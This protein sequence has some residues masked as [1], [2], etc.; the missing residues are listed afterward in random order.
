MQLVPRLFCGVHHISISLVFSIC[1]IC[2]HAMK[3]VKSIILKHIGDS[4][5]LFR[6]ANMLKAFLTFFLK[7]IQDGQDCQPHPGRVQ[8][9]EPRRA[10]FNTH[11]NTPHTRSTPP[12]IY[13]IQTPPP[14]THHPLHTPHTPSHRHTHTHTHPRTPPHTRTPPPHWPQRLAK[15]INV[16]NLRWKFWMTLFLQNYVSYFVA[17]ADLCWDVNWKDTNT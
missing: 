2:I 14:H 17:K 11:T 16:E 3:A 5:A 13:T 7:I 8:Y 15:Y 1:V 9:I 10:L 6:V 12:H 4:L